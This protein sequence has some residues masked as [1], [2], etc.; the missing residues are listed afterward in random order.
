M[1]YDFVSDDTGSVLQVT[2]VKKS[3][4]SAINLTGATVTL[5]WYSSSK[6]IVER[7]MTIV[8][9]LSG[10]C[11]YQFVAGELYAPAMSFEVEVL[12]NS[13]KKTSM[14]EPIA[15]KVRQQYN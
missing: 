10:I 4:G 3:D 1:S 7:P 2:C 11:T 8:T 13:G 14:L 6:V 9:P 15:V 12:D 5:R